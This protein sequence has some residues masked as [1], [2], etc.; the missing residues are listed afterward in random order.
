MAAPQISNET[1]AAIK[2]FLESK[3][4]PPSNA[5][6]GNYFSNA[7][8]RNAPVASQQKSALFR[9]LASD[10][11]TSLQVVHQSQY[12]PA[13]VSDPGTKEQTLAGPITTQVLDIEEIGSSRW[14][15]VESIEAHERGETTKGREIIRVVPDEEDDT[16]DNAASTV[17]STTHISA[18]PHKLLLQDA[19]GNKIYGFE[20]TA[21][22]T[23]NVEKLAI[24]AKLVLRN[25]VI[26][27][28]LVLLEPRNVEILGGKID[29]WDKKWRTERKETLK[30][31]AG[32]HETGE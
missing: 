31:K 8:G 24:G 9:I 22:P 5:W 12:L 29:A 25:V 21:M 32:M 6:L 20:M 17:T 19:K 3:N 26:A 16:N 28:G 30:R 11:T 7:T 2:S 23:V 1:K 27:R 13:N 14:S 15:Q 4:L 18:G 10:I